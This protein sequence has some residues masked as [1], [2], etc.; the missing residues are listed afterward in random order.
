MHMTKCSSGRERHRWMRLL[1]VGDLRLRYKL[2]GTT[3]IFILLIVLIVS[4]GTV[5]LGK[6][7][8][9]VETIVHR[10]YQSASLAN[11]LL[12]LVHETNA[13][14]RTIVSAVDAKQIEGV[15]ELINRNKLGSAK[16]LADMA[17]RATD[18]REKELLSVVSVKQQALDSIL[19]EI[20]G[21]TEELKNNVFQLS[22]NQQLLIQQVIAPKFQPAQTELLAATAAFSDY[23]RHAMEESGEEAKSVYGRARTAFL[24]MAAL[25]L[26]VSVGLSVVIMRAI[27]R[28]IA[29][30]TLAA[31]AIASGD[32]AYRWASRKA[33]R[34]EIGQLVTALRDMQ[35]RLLSLVGVIRSSSTTLSATVHQLGDA[36]GVIEN[37]AVGTSQSTEAI[38]S[39]IEQMTVSIAHVS[40]SA[41]EVGQKAR[42]AEECAGQGS[43][44][45]QDA[46]NEI[47]SI[48]GVVGCAAEQIE[49]LSKRIHSVSQ[50]VALIRDVAEQTNLLAL[51]AAIEA[52]RAGEQGRGFAVVADEVRKLAERT[53][54][55]THEIE[56]TAQALLKEAGDAAAGIQ[57][58]TRRIKDGVA[59]T[60]HASETMLSI[61]RTAR[62][63][64][65]SANEMATMLAEQKSASEQV[66]QQVERIAGVAE[67]NA[68]SVSSAVAAVQSIEVMT[69]ELDQAISAFR[70]AD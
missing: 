22:L 59:L 52:A 47:Q 21:R 61:T 65:S 14:V 33:A 9:E 1:N 17:S 30:A 36:A 6:V 43:L 2:G 58:G 18:A 16:S 68:E 41:H 37:G 7:N 19:G 64:L 62:E 27:G 10:R 67:R 32:L 44:A 55:S 20:L 56:A 12:R 29:E 23:E 13:L 35:E 48:S 57:A 53:Q 11:E 28:P 50:M 63:L 4:I 39:A 46:A 24:L 51:N 3:A 8:S 49:S 15:V 34:D 25:A 69:T 5:S 54:A 26:V 42:V 66:A 70:L 45:V 31:K 60:T 40:V 38:A